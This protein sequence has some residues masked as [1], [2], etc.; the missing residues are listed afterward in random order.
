MRFL[1]TIILL[2]FGIFVT[3][4]QIVSDSITTL[5]EI[6]SWKFDSTLDDNA[7][8][9]DKF[10]ESVRV[11]A[12]KDNLD[13]ITVRAY[14]SPDGPEKLNDRLS[15]KRCN[16]I[17]NLIIERTGVNPDLVTGISEG[18]AWGR[19]RDLVN[20]TPEVPSRDKILDI[21]DNTPLYVFDSKGRI[22]DGRKK[23]LMDLRGGVP[24]RWMLRNLFPK[25]RNAIAVTVYLRAESKPESSEESAADVA[26][27][28]VVEVTVILPQEVNKPKNSDLTP[29][30][31]PEE[32]AESYPRPA[33]SEQ[34]SAHTPDYPLALKT[35][36]LYY[37]ALM[38]NLELEWLFR[39]KWSV[40]LEG[41]VAWWSKKSDH[42]CYQIAVIDAEVRRWI[43]PRSQWH[44]MFVG[45]FAGGGWYDLENGGTGYHGEGGMTGLSF[46]YMWPVSRTLSFETSAGA[47]YM[48]TRYKEYIPFEGHLVYQRT[49][50]LNYFGPLKLKFSLVWRFWDRNKSRRIIQAI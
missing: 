29:P 11:A 30:I 46:G 42:K 35:N 32:V 44:G 15:Q 5:F 47:G 13:H 16:T 8:S 17:V 24:Y 21:L 48:Y 2:W 36:L 12:E 40:A 20:E 39:E 49:K 43:R 33:G 31:D 34:Q 45:L 3:S 19:L 9:M 27:D 7:A 50:T 23:Q 18:V 1:I 25:L 37:A 38:P 10:I 26:D 6:N 41:N 28:E 14:A 22:V 4:G